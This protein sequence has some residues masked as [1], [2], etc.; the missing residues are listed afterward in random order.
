MIAGTGIRETHL[1]K[2]RKRFFCIL[3]LTVPIPSAH[4]E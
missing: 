2:G 1:D 3:E 4:R